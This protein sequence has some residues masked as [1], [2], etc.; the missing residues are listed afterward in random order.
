MGQAEHIA[1]PGDRRLEIAH[2]PRN[3]PDGT[4]HGAFSH[5]RSSMCGTVA[6]G[7]VPVFEIG[8]GREGEFADG[9]GHVVLHGVEADAEAPP[10]RAVTHAVPD[11]VGHPPL[12][13]GQL[14][15][16]SRTPSCHQWGRF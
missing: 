11:C 15:G 4:K 14:I 9:V 2:L 1:I 7:A 12:G 5:R 8:S 3:L 13:R 16:V 10:D 6:R